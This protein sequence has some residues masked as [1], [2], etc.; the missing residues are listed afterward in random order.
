MNYRKLVKRS[1]ASSLPPTRTFPARLLT[2]QLVAAVL[3][4]AVNPASAK[5]DVI[6]DRILS[7]VRDTLIEV[8]RGTEGRLKLKEATLKLQTV[9]KAEAG[10]KATLFVI[11]IG[12]SVSTDAT[13]S[14]TLVLAPPADGDSQQASSNS[15]QLAAA[16]L[17]GYQA[18]LA[19]RNAT[20][21]L[22]LKTLNSSI[23]FA[24]RA[25]TGASG[26]IELLPITM[27]LS[28]EISQ[29]NIQEISLTFCNGTCR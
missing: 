20:P 28:G 7:D 16:I 11:S 26:G 29:S 24:V 10:G 12:S 18:S 3:M 9:Y 5:T 13:Q 1:S 17:A 25:E 23:K 22:A 14:L 19:A 27:E 6:L 21:P 15:D 4:I 2:L 8:N